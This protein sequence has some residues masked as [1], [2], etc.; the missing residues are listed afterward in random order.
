MPLPEKVIEQLGREPSSTHGWAI[1]ALLFSGGILF[2]AI[3][4]YVGLAFGYEP[5]VQ[6]QLTAEQ[7]KVSAL[8][9]S[10]PGNDQSQLIGYYSQI[11]NLQVL[12]QQHTAATKL[13]SWLEKNTE[14]NIYFQSLSLTTGNQITLTG[15]GSTEADINQQVAIFENAPEVTLVNV[16]NVTAPQLLGNGWTFNIAI[17]MN[18]SVLQGSSQ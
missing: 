3:A 16:S 13:F 18:S 14:A 2:F 11:A 1:G 12:L 4:M 7:N 17:V 5:Y 8:N 10:I 6:S 15:I 9:Q